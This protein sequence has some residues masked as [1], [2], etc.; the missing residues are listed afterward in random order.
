MSIHTLTSGGIA[1]GWGREDEEDDRGGCN[2]LIYLP[3]LQSA[4]SRSPIIGTG[5]LSGPA[6]KI[7]HV[8]RLDI[9]AQ[10]QSTRGQRTLLT[11][12]DKRK[13]SVM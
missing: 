5:V 10:S 6:E 2:S 12:V 11:L 4:G 3:I 1:A 7:K 9:G 8:I 13:S